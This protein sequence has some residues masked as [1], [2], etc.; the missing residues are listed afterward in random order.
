MCLVFQPVISVGMERSNG[1][2]ME[3]FRL[4]SG[5]NCLTRTLEILMRPFDLPYFLATAGCFQRGSSWDRYV[6]LANTFL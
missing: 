3:I 4:N 1:I 6:A 5:V 2:P